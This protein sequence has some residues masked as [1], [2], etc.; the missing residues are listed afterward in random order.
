MEEA[1]SEFWKSAIRKDL[2]E[3]D[4]YLTI[5]GTTTVTCFITIQYRQIHITY[6]AA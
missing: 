3:R 4:R 2:Q 6:I 1:V 5:F